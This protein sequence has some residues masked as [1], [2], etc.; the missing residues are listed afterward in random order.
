MNKEGKKNERERVGSYQH[1]NSSETDFCFPFQSYFG[2]NMTMTVPLVNHDL[3]TVTIM[4]KVIMVTII[5]T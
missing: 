1:L 2:L 3:I 4:M 5:R